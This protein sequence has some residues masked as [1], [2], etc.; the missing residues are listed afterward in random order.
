MFLCT[1][2]EVC[3]QLFLQKCFGEASWAYFEPGK[4][5]IDRDTLHWLDP[6]LCVWCVRR[7]GIL[8]RSIIEDAGSALW[9]GARSGSPTAGLFVVEGCTGWPSA[10]SWSNT[11]AISVPSM[12]ACL[13]TFPGDSTDGHFVLPLCEFEYMRVLYRKIEHLSVPCVQGKKWKRKAWEPH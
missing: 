2:N 4:A 9:N 11:A 8:F 12:E 7:G 6:C 3:L 13:W 1:P 5:C 10:W